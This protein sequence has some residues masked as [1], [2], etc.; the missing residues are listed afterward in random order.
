M[1]INRLLET[2][3]NIKATDCRNIKQQNVKQISLF[4]KRV[5]FQLQV[6]SDSKNLHF[7]HRRLI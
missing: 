1:E 2:L 7:H 3:D 5:E 4:H 6:W